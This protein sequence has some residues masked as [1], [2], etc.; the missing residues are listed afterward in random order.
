VA[1][2]FAPGDDARA[3]ANRFSEHQELVD[4]F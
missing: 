4:R 1:L 3:R 2:G